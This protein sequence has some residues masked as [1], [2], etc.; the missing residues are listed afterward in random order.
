MDGHQ[1]VLI[2]ELFQTL[3]SVQF[4]NGDFFCWTRP[5]KDL[6]QG[7]LCVSRSRKPATTG[8]PTEKR[9]LMDGHY[10]TSS[11]REKSWA[12]IWLLSKPFKWI[13]PERQ[14]ATHRPQPL[15]RTGLTSALPA[16]GPVS[17][18]NGAE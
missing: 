2:R 5:H 3:L 12:K 16:L 8:K 11:L 6:R 4:I 7:V 10:P 14:D 15:H 1:P 17:V 9:P 13:A 18:K